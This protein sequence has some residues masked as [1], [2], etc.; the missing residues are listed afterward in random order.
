MKRAPGGKKKKI[1]IMAACTSRMNH[2]R[3]EGENPK[4][5]MLMSNLLNNRTTTI[6]QVRGK[7]GG[8]KGNRTYKP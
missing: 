1:G 8:E 7:R 4:A 6:E 3:K 5:D 2:G